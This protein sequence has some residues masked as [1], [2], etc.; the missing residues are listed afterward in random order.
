MVDYSQNGEQPHVIAFVEAMG[1]TTG[2]I[3]E[4]GAGDGTTM[5]NTKALRDM[6]WT[7]SLYDGE[8]SGPVKQA[9]I[10]LEWLKKQRDLSCDLFCIDLDGND[11]HILEKC[12]KAKTFKPSLIVAEIN[13]I[14]RR[15]EV[16]IMPYKAD[17]QW[18]H[19][20]WY[21]MSL[22]AAERLCTMHGYVLAYL[23][24]GINAFF[25]KQEHAHLCRPIDYRQKWDHRAHQHQTPW[26]R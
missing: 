26:I 19:D 18:A 24:A 6:G 15:D 4:Y 17:H 23:H 13:P 14:F 9:W 5:S 1:L 20:T 8:A 11:Y 7:A 2:H 25:V 22:A 10:T 12:L 3:L 21:G 16:A